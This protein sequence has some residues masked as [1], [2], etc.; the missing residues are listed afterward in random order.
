VT[1]RHRLRSLLTIAYWNGILPMR[2]MPLFLLNTIASPLS[3]LFF[4]VVVSHG[5][6]LLYGVAGGIVLTMLSI[7][8]SVQTDMS[9]YK[10]DLKLHDLVVA[11]PVEAPIYVAGLA[12]SEFLFAIPGITLFLVIWALSGASITLL[13]A[14]TVAL[15]LILVWGFASALGFTLAT[16]FEDIRETFVFSPLLSLALTVLPPIYYPASF[17]PSWLR[18][19]AYLSPATYA[20][21]LVHR[22]MGL[23]SFNGVPEPYLLPAWADILALVAFAVAFFLIAAKKARW[24]EP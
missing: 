7:G 21:D 15:A 3:F 20:V 4:I 5:A 11:S 16:Y 19:F 12:V 1:G 8:T 14:L 23:T 13:S 9:H 22:A 24:R 17:L 2:R 6:L 18:P 10:S